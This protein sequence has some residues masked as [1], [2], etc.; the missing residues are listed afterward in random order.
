MLRVLG[1]FPSPANCRPRRGVVDLVRLI[2]S[3]CSLN[4]TS[5]YFLGSHPRIPNRL[6]FRFTEYYLYVLLSFF[7]L[8]LNTRFRHRSREYLP[9]TCSIDSRNF[10][11]G[12]SQ[13][14]PTA[15]T[16]SGIL[17]LPACAQSSSWN[18]KAATAR[19]PATRRS[20]IRSAIHL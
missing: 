4:P 8:S 7:S 9:E 1:T 3:L 13:E 20:E 2:F 17:L 5:H 15:L 11:Y 12:L 6:W 19:K 16:P 10:S 14:R 18:L